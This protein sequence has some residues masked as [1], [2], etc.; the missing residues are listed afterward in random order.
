MTPIRD[1]ATHGEQYV[2]VDELAGY[3]RVHRD[4]IYN[5]VRKGALEAVKVGVIIRIPVHS[6]RRY[7]GQPAR[8]RA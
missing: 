5:A 7:A 3:L 1:L 8:H 6:A 4:T 2:T